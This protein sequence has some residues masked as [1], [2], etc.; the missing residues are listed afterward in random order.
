MIETFRTYFLAGR[1]ADISIF[2]SETVPGSGDAYVRIVLPGALLPSMVGA[3]VRRIE[4]EPKI[5]DLASAGISLIKTQRDDFASVLA[6]LGFGGL[7][8]ELRSKTAGPTM[9]GAAP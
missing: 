8:V 2:S 3:R 7:L 6:K 9:L 5:I 4:G 1:P